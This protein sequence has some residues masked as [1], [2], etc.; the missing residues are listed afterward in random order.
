[1]VVYDEELVV[2]LSHRL[3]LG[4]VS[5]VDPVLGWDRAVVEELAGLALAVVVVGHELLFGH[6]GLVVVEEG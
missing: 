3:A 6:K 4:R 2:D 5:S 1:M